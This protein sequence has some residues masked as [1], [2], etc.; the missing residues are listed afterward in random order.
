VAAKP[1]VEDPLVAKAFDASKHED[2]ARAVEKLSPEEAQFFLHK[3]EV[4]LRKRKIQL[5]GYLVAIIAWVVLMVA[6]L[7]Y[8][9]IADGFVGWAF[10]VPFAVVG[11]ILYGFG[12]WANKVGAAKPLPEAIIR[13]HEAPGL[14]D[15]ADRSVR[16]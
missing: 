15:G 16:Q 10:L 8:F 2:L 14:A 6:A 4:A 11:A 12:R 3:L 1:P 13:D 5:L 7:A 9:G